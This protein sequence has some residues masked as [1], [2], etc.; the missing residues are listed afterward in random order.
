MTDKVLIT[1]ENE[2]QVKV[3]NLRKVI[4]KHFVELYRKRPKN[5]RFNPMFKL[6]KWDG[7]IYKFTESGQTYIGLLP[8][9][10][11]TLIS[12][13]EK[14]KLVDKRKKYQF[15]DIRIDENYLKDLRPDVILGEHQ[16]NCVNSLF[17]NNGGLIRAG[18]GAGKTFMCAAISRYYLEMGLRVVIIVPTGDLV[19]QTHAEIASFGL[20]VGR[21]N[22]DYK[23]LDQDIICGTWQSIAK[24]PE[25]M[26]TFNVVILDECHTIGGPE[27]QKIITDFCNHMPVRIGMTGTL[28]DN[29]CDAITLKS[30]F[31]EIQ[32]EVPAS[33]LIDKGWLSSLKIKQ[34]ILEEN[35]RAKYEAF[36]ATHP[37]LVSDT[38][39]KEFKNGYFPD[40][41]S[42][43]ASVAKNKKR[44]TFISAL[45][46]TLQIKN[47]FERINSLILVRSVDA[48]QYLAKKIPNAVFIYSKDSG[49]V[50]KAIYESFASNDNI[51]AIT[52]FQLASTGLN[53]PRIY[54]LFLVDANKSFTQ[55]VQSIGRGLRKAA[56]K[57]HIMVYD[58]SSDLKFCTQHRNKRKRYYLDE[59]FPL[60]KQQKIDYSTIE[61]EYIE[62]DEYGDS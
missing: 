54:N 9:I 46:Q 18:T 43:Y 2:V 17:A 50:R 25:L 49:K 53:I 13:G 12:V 37:E 34:I 51:T 60:D 62:E 10:V 48:G 5:Y 26:S 24:R 32:Y 21:L 14:F 27:I 35:M 42:E 3:E 40:Y 41:T 19:V 56:D 16:V 61:F 52:T 20:N 28:P 55:I 1:I 29:E 11:E 59:G 33:E 47:D 31:G 15:D 7:Y 22:K 45:V 6:K 57:N 23:E 8:E 38:S 58:I 44:L 36:C 4:R 30:L 39:Y